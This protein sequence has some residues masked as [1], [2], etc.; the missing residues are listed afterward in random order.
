MKGLLSAALLLTAM[1]AL[2]ASILGIN[3][4]AQAVVRINVKD[5]PEHG[6]S[7]LAPSDP[8]FDALL[9]AVVASDEPVELLKPY[10]IFLKNTGGRSVIAYKLRWECAKADGTVIHKDSSISSAWVLM[11]ED[12]AGV[13]DAPEVI[14]PNSIWFYSLVAPPRRLGAAAG[15]V[16]SGGWAVVLDR[17]K[18]AG[19][20]GS[21]GRPTTAGALQLLNTELGRYASITV[22]LDGALFDDGTFV[23]PDASGFFGA[24]KAEVDAKFDLLAEIR[25]GRLRGKSEEEIF[26]TIDEAAGGPDVSLGPDSTADDY[27][28]LHKKIF[29][30]EL[31][32]YGQAVGRRLAMTRALKQLEKPWV[33]VRKL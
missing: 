25:N 26:R 17:K 20:S 32:G 5:L 7:I 13:G 29:A 1:A 12:G 4:S 24:V 16:D 23:G 14:R 3:R 11:N 31:L 30:Q 15:A 33:R 19:G 2:L 27:Y 8:S 6:L 21:A 10:S 9:S 18:V 22:T 28:K